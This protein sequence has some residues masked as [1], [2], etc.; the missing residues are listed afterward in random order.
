MSLWELFADEDT[1]KPR[2]HACSGESCQV[3]ATD[4]A[5]RKPALPYNGTSGWSG[6]DT[7]RQR[8]VTADESGVTSERQARTVELLRDREYDGLTW[9]ELADATGWH[10]GTASGVLSVLHKAGTISRL[11][12]S[13]DRCK[14][15]VLPEY[16]DGREREAQGRTRECPNCGHHF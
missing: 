15:Y 1:D 8:A 9:K 3:C 13:R 11:N 5:Q 4:R 2:T 10:H 14:I 7:S 12:Q 6:T 16:E